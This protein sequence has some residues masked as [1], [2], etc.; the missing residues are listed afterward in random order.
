MIHRFEIVAA[1]DHV[2]TIRFCDHKDVILLGSEVPIAGREMAAATIDWLRTALL[3]DWLYRI[4]RERAHQGPRFSLFAPNGVRCVS[5]TFSSSDRM[6]RT[7]AVLKRNCRVA[8]VVTRLADPFGC[9]AD[10]RPVPACS[11]PA[12]ALS[13]APAGAPRSAAEAG[14]LGAP[15]ATPLSRS[16][17]RQAATVRPGAAQGEGNSP[18]ASRSSMASRIDGSSATVSIE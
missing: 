9:A 7:I 11:M 1:G 8:P 10:A 2:P 14:I 17:G 12:A 6:E 4:D 5:P 3:K 13:V 18:R 16:P 15:I